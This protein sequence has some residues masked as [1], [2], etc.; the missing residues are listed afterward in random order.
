MLFIWE[1]FEQAYNWLPW[2]NREGP[3][4]LQNRT[5]LHN[6]NR[7]KK[8]FTP[9]NQCRTN[10]F[11]GREFFSTLPVVDGPVVYHKK[12]HRGLLQRVYIPRFWH[13]IKRNDAREFRLKTRRNIEK[14]RRHLDP[15]TFWFRPEIRRAKV[16]FFKWWT[17][18][19]WPFGFGGVVKMQTLLNSETFEW[20]VKR[21]IWREGDPFQGKSC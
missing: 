20:E 13:S 11:R 1:L 5:N 18:R 9:E 19:P 12:P 6:C 17:C 16:N 7:K 10:F 8:F 15:M 2:L 3:W 4:K 14:E 21:A